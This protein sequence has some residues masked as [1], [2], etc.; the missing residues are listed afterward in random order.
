MNDYPPEVP[1][2]SGSGKCP[3][4]GSRTK[5]IINDPPY[6]ITFCCAKGSDPKCTWFVEFRIE[7]EEE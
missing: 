2:P 1:A 6:G 5:S 7:E 3:L 4:C